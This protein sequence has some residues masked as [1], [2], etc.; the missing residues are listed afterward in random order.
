LETSPDAPSREVI[1]SVAEAVRQGKVVSIPT[2]TLYV[3][4][5][6]PFNLN[7]VASVFHAK[8]REL[9]RSL[10]ILVNSLQMAEDYATHLTS[11]FYLLARRFWP[12]PLTIIVPASAKLPLRVTGH[13]GRLAVRQSAAAIPHQLIEMLDMPLIAT[14]ANVSGQPTCRSG[15]EVLGTMDGRVDLLLDAGPVNGLGATTVDI[16]E[17]EWRVIREGAISE[18]VIAE[19]LQI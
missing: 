8:G 4:A 9:D 10:P 19:N 11:R 17:P 6:D 5:A 3:L 18:A 2:D 1:A 16:T 13:T 12:G 14:S 15:F 7:A